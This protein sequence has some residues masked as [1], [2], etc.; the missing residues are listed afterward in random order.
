MCF[1]R[2]ERAKKDDELLAM[3]DEIFKTFGPYAEASGL[4]LPDW[5][6]RNVEI[7]R[8]FRSDPIL[9]IFQICDLAGLD[10]LAVLS[11]SLEAGR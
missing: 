9:G 7:E 10:P 3:N 5:I 11:H 2:R 4:S 6:R 8:T 1:G